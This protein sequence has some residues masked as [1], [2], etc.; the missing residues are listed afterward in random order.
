LKVKKAEAGRCWHNRQS[1]CWRQL[2][3]V[4]DRPF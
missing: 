3:A 2:R 4:R 1:D